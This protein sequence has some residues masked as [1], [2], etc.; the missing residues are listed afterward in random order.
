M[1]TEVAGGEVPL[2]P[3]SHSVQKAQIEIIINE[4][5][6]F[7]SANTVSENDN[8]T[9]IPDTGKAR[10]GVYPP[11]YPLN[12]CLK[13]I[14]GDFKS[15]IPDTIKINDRN[16]DDYIKQLSDWKESDYSHKAVEAVF[17]NVKENTVTSDCIKSGIL[18]I[19]ENSGKVKEKQLGT[20]VDKCFVRFRTDS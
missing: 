12:D 16:H 17:N 18:S 9:I 5:G 10:T 11:P 7:V 1:G 4:D 13:Y 15:F 19:D 14:A 3:V 20:S 8:A 2:L 6:K